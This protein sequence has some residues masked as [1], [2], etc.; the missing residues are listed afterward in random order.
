MSVSIRTA[1]TGAVVLC[2]LGA[3]LN[4]RQKLKIA[5]TNYTALTD[6]VTVYK[7]KIGGQT[8]S[9]ATL[10][11][12]NATFRKAILQKDAKLKALS[13]EFARV[14]SV[15]KTI[16]NTKLDTI[17]IA[18]TDSVPFAFSRNGTLK[19]RWY[20][21]NYASDADGVTITQLE[22]PDTTMVITGIKKSWFLGKETMVTDVTHANPFVKVK[23]IQS[24]EITIP[25]P[26]YKKWFVWL[27][28]GIAGGLL[29][30]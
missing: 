30:K 5:E 26:W 13:S 28:A 15:V 25:T 24:A 8:A 14:K 22:I 21:L 16:T 9:I 4:F 6:S 11:L 19:E 18:Y 29:L 7:N 12:D 20:T 2:L 3:L 1:I 23:T 27:A 17:R 10:Q